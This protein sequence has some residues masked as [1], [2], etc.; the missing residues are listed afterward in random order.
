MHPGMGMEL[1]KRLSNAEEKFAECLSWLAVKLETVVQPQKE[2]WVANPHAN[3]SGF[4]NIPKAK[5]AHLF[6][7]IPDIEK[8]NAVE[9]AD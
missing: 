9:N 6:I 7:G 4:A 3:S 2:I 8:A 5:I 1:S